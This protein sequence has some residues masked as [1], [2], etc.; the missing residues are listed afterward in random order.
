MFLYFSRHRGQCGPVNS[1]ECLQVVLKTERVVTNSFLDVA[2]IKLAEPLK[3][4]DMTNAVCL[5]RGGVE[6]KFTGYGSVNYWYKYD[7]NYL[8]NDTEVIHL[9]ESEC[10]EKFAKLKEEFNSEHICTVFKSPLATPEKKVYF[11]GSSL[12]FKMENEVFY[13]VGV[14]LPQASTDNPMKFVATKDMLQWISTEVKAP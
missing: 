11:T 12:Q 1:T 14:G 8:Y 5:R 4:D 3:F 2:L 7:T 10:K 13:Q 6:S 9:N